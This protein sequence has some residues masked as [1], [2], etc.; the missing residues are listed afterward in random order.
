MPKSGILSSRNESTAC[1]ILLFGLNGCGKTTLGRELARVLGFYP[2]DHEN[3]AFEPSALPYAAPCPPADCVRLM[4]ADIQSRGSFVLSAVT[5]DF[6]EEITAML[7]LAV[8]L[9]VPAE[10]R[11][12]RVEER[13]F[14]RYG[15]RIFEGGDLFAQHRQFTN[16]ARS[17]PAEPIER[18]ARTLP[19]PLLHIGVRASC[20]KNAARF[21]W[22]SKAAA[23]TLSRRRLVKPIP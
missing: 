15:E 17:R 10:V 7:A 19:C 6:G 9:E 11:L 22:Q 4:L 14:R 13:E 20:A 5:S 16:F 12:Q 8:L 18:W 2:I 3:Y 23:R 21:P 1:G